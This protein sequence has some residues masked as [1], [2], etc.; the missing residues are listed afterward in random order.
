M[1]YLDKTKVTF[2]NGNAY[3]AEGINEKPF[4]V[5]TYDGIVDRSLIDKICEIVREHV[6]EHEGDFCNVKITAQDWDC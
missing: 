6:N 3:T 5:F 2:H 4:A 1:P